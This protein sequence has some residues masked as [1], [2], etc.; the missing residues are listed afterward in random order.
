MAKVP[1][2]TNFVS[3]HPFSQWIIKKSLGY[4]DAPALSVPTLKQQL[5]GHSSR[6]YDLE[7]LENIPDVERNKY[8]LVVQDPFNS[9]YEADTV[10][11]F[12]QLI[13]NGL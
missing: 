12:I 8:V 13:E 3:Q 1:R 7:A 9:Y 4:V 6:G 10:Y 5:D 2:L 11:H